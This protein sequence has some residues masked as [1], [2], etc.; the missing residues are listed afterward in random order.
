MHQAMVKIIIDQVLSQFENES[1]FYREYLE[2]DGKQ[3]QGWKEGRIALEAEVM[4]KM[5]SL[6]S[7]YE[8]MLAQKII[9]QTILFPEKRNYV[10]N[11]YKR[12]KVLIAKKWL[13]SGE[14]T[15]ELISQKTSLSKGLYVN[16]RKEMINLRVSM[17]YDAWGYDDILVFTLP[18]VIQ[19]QIEESRVDLLEWVSENLTDTY[20]TNE[21]VE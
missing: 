18:A 3:W 11:E 7:D 15:L 17:D 13:Q 2:I 1:R 19:Q 21:T 14:A 6:F 12:V 4:S 8:W 20:V 10:V 5:K 16:Q 9:H